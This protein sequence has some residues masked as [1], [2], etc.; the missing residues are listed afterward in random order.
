MKPVPT[1][2]SAC[3]EPVDVDAVI[4][5]IYGTLLISSAGEPVTGVGRNKTAALVSAMEE[6]GL[7]GNLPAAAEKGIQ[8]LIDAIESAHN[9]SRKAGID[10]PE[11]NIR[12]TWSSIFCELARQGL[13]DRTPKNPEVDKAVVSFECTLNPTWPMPGMN[14]IITSLHGRGKML[15]VVSNAQFYTPIVFEALSGANFKDLGFNPELMA[16]SWQHRAAKPST[17]LFDPILAELDE[18]GLDPRR[19]LYVGND[20]LNDIY[21]AMRCGFRTALFAG[22]KRSLRL[23]ENNPNCVSIRPDMVITS[24]CQLEDMI[25]K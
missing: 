19:V 22:D 10:Y 8:K 24:L 2:L 14:E 9:E 18:R 16:F 1:G 11:I 5:D 12:S 20:M 4:F 6:A 17:R 21:A 7:S 13:L 3:G 23:R 15:G 25:K